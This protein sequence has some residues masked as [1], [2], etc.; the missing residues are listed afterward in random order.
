MQKKLAIFLV[1][2]LVIAV[3]NFPTVQGFTA[4]SGTWKRA[5]EVR[6]TVFLVSIFF[7]NTLTAHQLNISS[8]YSMTALQNLGPS[9]KIILL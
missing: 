6:R 1:I 8:V 2:A 9:C 3:A 4:G 5:L 7:A